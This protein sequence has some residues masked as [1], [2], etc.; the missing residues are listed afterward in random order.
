VAACRELFG[1]VG[2]GPEDPLWE[3]HG[4]VARQYLAAGGASANELAEWTEVQRR[5]EVTDGP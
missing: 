4:D 1:I 3:L 5:R 2:S